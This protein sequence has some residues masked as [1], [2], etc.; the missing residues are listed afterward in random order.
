[1]VCCNL[2]TQE[3]IF[4]VWVRTIT[5]FIL[6]YFCFAFLVLFSFDRNSTS[7]IWWL[8]LCHVKNY[9]VY[10]T[11]RKFYSTN[12]LIFCHISFKFLS[13]SVS[14]KILTAQVSFNP[15]PFSAWTPERWSLLWHW[16]AQS[17]SCFILV[18]TTFVNVRNT[19]CYLLFLLTI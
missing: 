7:S 6:F 5:H 10:K 17:H 11:Y 3:E 19:Y 15:S 8:N 9:H 1:M 12:K 18:Y 16:C 4:L 2:L 13:F 14:N